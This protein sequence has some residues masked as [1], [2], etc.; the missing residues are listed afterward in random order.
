MP[1]I[2]VFDIFYDLVSYFFASDHVTNTGVVELAS[3][4]LTMM[5]MYFVVIAP[6]MYL[7]GLGVFRRK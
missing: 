3:I 4:T 5:F 6:V 1:D 2:K 7:L